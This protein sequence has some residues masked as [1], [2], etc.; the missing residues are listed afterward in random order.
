ML[1][2]LTVIGTRPEAIK[3]APVVE[4]LGRYPD[5]VHSLVCVTGQHRQMLDQVLALF[6]IRPNYDLNLMQP[7]Q[8]LD[9]LTA[10]LFWGLGSVVSETKPSWVV[11]QGDTTTVLV[12][13]L[14]AFYHRVRFAHIEAGL[15]S[16]DRSQPFPE[17]VNRR[18][19]DSLS[20]VFFAPT[21][22]ARRALIHEGYPEQNI[23]VTGNTVV[24]A[25]STVAAREY[26]W[27]SGPLASVPRHQRV[28]LVTAHRR[29]SFGKTMEELC[30]AIRDLAAK[31][32]EAGIHFVYPVHPSPNVFWPVRRLLSGLSNVSLLEPL[33]Y[34]SFVQVMKRSILILTDSGGLQEEAPSLG[35]PVLV[36]RDKTERPEGIETGVVRL[37]G[38]ERSRIVAEAEHLLRDPQS[39]AAMTGKVNPFG[40]GK[41]A[42]RIVA[43][44][45]A[46]DRR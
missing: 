43:A 37:V 20:D 32:A 11:A 6:D 5:R 17:E 2:V 34:L 46:Q 16:G 36:M 10:K 31:F 9:K 19:V 42:I 4:E 7:D 15:R 35:V 45:L 40:D 38:T 30:L 25:L 22:R 1:T 24:D 27:T 29:E 28:V 44:L 14:V 12:A 41:A 23:Y 13:A 8:E 21:E 33:D 18:I 26:D 39:R 3:M